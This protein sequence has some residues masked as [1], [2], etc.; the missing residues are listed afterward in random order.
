M[1]LK[2]MN[3]FL[4][5][6]YSI[7]DYFYIRYPETTYNLYKISKIYG[8]KLIS[9]HQSKEIDELKSFKDEYQFG[10]KPSKFLSWFQYY[11]YPIINESFFGNRY[12]KKIKAIITVTDE[13]AIH[14][15]NKG[16]KNVFVVPNGL[17]VLKY[18]LSRNVVN[19]SEPIKFL[20]L[21]GTSTNASWNGL[22]RLI[23]SIDKLTNPVE[24]IKVIV[25]GHKIEDEIPERNYI[26]HRGYLN[27]SS[28]DELCDEIHIGISTLALYKKK[29]NEAATLKTREYIS[30]GIPFIYAYTDPDLNEEAKEFSLQFPNDDSLIDMEQVI[31]FAKKTLSNPELP[32]KMRKYALEHLDYE[33]KMKKLVQILLKL[34]NEN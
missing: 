34:K 3:I 19:S 17:E 29:L 24:K 30:R 33:V 12:A 14:Q 22:D 1:L 5:F 4:E 23:A 21:K 9:E 16:N 2:Q 13:I 18:K 27:G 20:F 25:C 32:Q 10:I 11:F 6:N 28:L 8:N 7:C 26:E 31:D 15:S